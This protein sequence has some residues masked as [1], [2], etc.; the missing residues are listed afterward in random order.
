MQ[1]INSAPALGPVQAGQDA[2]NV[3]CTKENGPTWKPL[4]ESTRGELGQPVGFWSWG[5]RGS[6]A[7]CIPAVKEMLAAYKEVPAA[8]G[9]I[10]T[11]AQL[12]LAS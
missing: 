3:L 12:P 7:H 2:K 6:G 4:A 9:E 1:K 8:L 10:G 11:E 5:Y